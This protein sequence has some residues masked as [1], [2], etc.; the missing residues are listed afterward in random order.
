MA[1]KLIYVL[2]ATIIVLVLLVLILPFVIDAN[3][4]RPQIEAAADSALNRKVA[5]GNIRL[6][7]F[8]GGV[9]INDL[10]ISDDP[11]FGANAFLTTKSVAV[12]VEIR[13]LI[14]SRELRVT[15][16]RIDQPHITLLRSPSGI[17]NFSSLAATSRKPPAAG[18]GSA[19]TSTGAENVFVQKIEVA[20]GALSVGKTSNNKRNEYSEVNFEASDLSYTSQFPFTLAA[21][22]PGN[23]TLKLGGKAGPLNHSNTAETPLEAKVEVHNFDLSATDFV[24]PSSGIAGLLDFAGALTSD[25]RLFS[26]KGTISANR[27]KLVPGGSPASKAVQ[28]DYTIEYQAQPETGTLNQGDLRIGKAVAHL[29]GTFKNSGEEPSLQM[30]L[31]GENMPASDLQAVLPALGVTLPAGASLKEGMLN[32]S[33][34]IS[35]PVNRLVTAGPIKLSNAKLT[36]FDLGGKMGAL[37]SFAGLPKTSDTVIETFSSDVRIAP[38]GIRADNVNLVVPAIGSITGNGTVAANQMLDFKMIAHLSSS[39]SAIG[40]LAGV[41]LFGG[42]QKGNA[43]AIPFKIQGTTSNPVFIPDVAGIASGLG[44]G[45]LSGVPTGGQDLGKEL[46]G[47]FGGKKKQ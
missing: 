38:E 26:S 45:V 24:D 12:G 46:G 34:S 11:A 8:S 27:L 44:K 1:R 41:G 22:T 20:N 21:K 29:T 47:L 10:S 30:K 13:P 42:G 15:G 6:A 23:G 3:R 37:S 14:F 28:L 33:L 4:F 18:S 19:T 17:W 2:G 7:L 35:G 32:V 16:I 31:N 9:S 36:G 43:T 5:I 39:N 40:K 25:G